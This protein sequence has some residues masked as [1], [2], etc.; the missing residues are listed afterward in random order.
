MEW[1]DP[2]VGAMPD[3]PF[4]RIANIPRP[5]VEPLRAG[6]QTLAGA[7]RIRK[8]TV[9]IRSWPSVAPCT[10][11]ARTTGT[12][13]SQSCRTNDDCGNATGGRLC[14]MK[15]HG[16]KQSLWFGY[17]KQN[18]NHGRNSNR[19]NKWHNNISSG[20][21]VGLVIGDYLARSGEHLFTMT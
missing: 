20:W 15:T 21:L 11:H 4:V 12:A 3:A 6:Y 19:N 14:H 10:N 5:D 7:C 13:W 16:W 2:L 9:E 17:V 18:P 1:P 8:E